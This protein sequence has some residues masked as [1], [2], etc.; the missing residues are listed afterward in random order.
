MQTAFGGKCAPL[1]RLLFFSEGF[2]YFSKTMLNHNSMAICLPA[3][4]IWHT[5]GRVC[6]INTQIYKKKCLYLL[7]KGNEPN[8][9]QLLNVSHSLPGV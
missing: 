1:R 4:Q 9:N 6:C 2:V 5:F 8:V 7:T 3:V